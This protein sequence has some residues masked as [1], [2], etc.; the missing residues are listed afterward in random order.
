MSDQPENDTTEVGAEGLDNELIKSLRAQ[1]KEANQE[2]RAAKEAAQS[3]LE[4]ARREL[5]RETSAQRYVDAAGYPGLKDVVLEKVE[6]DL[7]VD[8]VKAA[9]E[10][11]SLPVPDD[12]DSRVQGG[13][14]PTEGVPGTATAV[15]QV[16]RTA[17]LG[18]QLASAAQ[19]DP[20]KDAIKSI[21]GAQTIDELVAASQEAG[22]YDPS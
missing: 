15:E 12:F 7:T 11:L 18:A 6:G 2:A 8:S 19:S 13:Q 20:S 22:I 3:A 17:S 1:V 16:A 9:F 14:T 5:Q 10:S 4:D 21:T